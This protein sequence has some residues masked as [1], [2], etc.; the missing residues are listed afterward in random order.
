MNFKTILSLIDKTTYF[1]ES[2]LTL[3]ETWILEKFKFILNQINQD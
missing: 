2:G 3:T 1:I